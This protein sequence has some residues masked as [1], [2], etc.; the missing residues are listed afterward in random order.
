MEKKK[1]MKTGSN[2]NQPYKTSLRK[3]GSYLGKTD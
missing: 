1:T 2:K 3:K